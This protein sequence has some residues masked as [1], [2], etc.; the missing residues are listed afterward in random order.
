MLGFLAQDFHAKCVTDLVVLKQ[1]IFIFRASPKNSRACVVLGIEKPLLHNKLVKELRIAILR[2]KM[3]SFKCIQLLSFTVLVLSISKLQAQESAQE[4]L[5]AR[6]GVPATARRQILS[7]SFN[8][9]MSVILNGVYRNYTTKEGE[10]HGFPVAEEGHSR[11]F[12]L[13]HSE[14][15]FLANAD[16]KFLASL[17]FAL[18]EHE[19]GGGHGGGGHVHKEDEQTEEGGLELEL[20]EAFIQT[21]PGFGLPDGMLIKAGQ[22]FWTLGYLNEHHSHYDDFTDRPLPYRVFLNN[23]FND[24][25]AELSYVLPSSLY[26]EF[27]AGAFAANDYPAS[28]AAGES[29]SNFL[30]IG[31]DIGQNHSFRIGAYQLVAQST[32]SNPR[33]SNG[34][35]LSFVGDTRLYIADLRYTWAPTA[36][37]RNMEMLL[38]SEYFWH[39]EK[40]VYR[41]EGDPHKEDDQTNFEGQFRGWYAQLVFKFRAQWRIGFRY[42]RLY[43]PELSDELQD[44][45]LQDTSFDNQGFSPRVSSLMIDWTN[46]EFSRVRVQYNREQL[47]PEGKEKGNEHDDQFLFQYVVSI[48][49]HAAHKY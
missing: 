11:G 42:S 14:L 35:E 30:R 6:P 40:G 25:G 28:S 15:H 10:I 21:L 31:R 17:T 26:I 7:R 37:P 20:E 8:P 41:L 2:G 1:L 23:V 34:G 12:S 4:E 32:V 43:S 36:N 39:N 46:S 49:A 47:L 22:A 13:D 29:W 18:A 24:K 45:E 19:H 27:G 3:F 9:S 5:Q 38:Q 44:H 48:G 16:D 33:I